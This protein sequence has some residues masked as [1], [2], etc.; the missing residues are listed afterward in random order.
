M[1]LNGGSI[2]LGATAH[3]PTGGSA[4]TLSTL[5]SD[6]SGAKLLI[7]DSAA[8][9]LR[10]TLNVSVVEPAANDTYPGGFTPAKRRVA[11]VKPITLASGE[12]FNNQCI[13]EIIVHPETSA[14]Q[15][16]ELRQTGVLVLNDADF[17]G[18]WGSGSLA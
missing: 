12:I 16:T 14:A 1:A 5:G 6:R 9:N 10:S 18:L 15:I 17:D 13:T 7:A 11:R 2:P 4:T 3:T 8:Y